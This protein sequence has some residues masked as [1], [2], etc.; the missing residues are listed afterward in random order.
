MKK[1]ERWKDS[2]PIVAWTLPTVVLLLILF[3]AIQL[4]PRQQPTDQQTQRHERFIF[5]EMR[6]YN[7]VAMDETLYV[8][9]YFDTEA[10]KTIEVKAYSWPAI[11]KVRRIMK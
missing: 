3:W 11:S 5:M 1:N 9:R 6:Q 10:Y 2:V 4:P 8:L 7:V